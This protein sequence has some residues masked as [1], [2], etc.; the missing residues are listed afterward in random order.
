MAAPTKDSKSM[1]KFGA[2]GAFGLRTCDASASAF[3]FFMVSRANFV[4]EAHGAV[5]QGAG[6]M[7]RSSISVHS[8]RC[9]RF[10]SREKV[11][12]KS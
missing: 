4:T 3:G 10:V 5:I 12:A 7:I 1:S 8:S 9:V 11:P 2:S 6:G